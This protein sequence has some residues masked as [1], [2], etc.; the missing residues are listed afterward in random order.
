M[1]KLLEL[2]TIQNNLRSSALS[3]SNN[4]DNMNTT[5]KKESKL[6][7]KH[8][9]IYGLGN[10][11][12]R[13]V[14]FLMI[15]IYTR[16]LSPTDYG[17]LEIVTLTT[18]II[19]LVASAGVTQGIV[20]FYF[21][22][23]SEKDK[24]EVMS[25]SIIAFSIVSLI[26]LIPVLCFSS[27]LAELLLDSSDQRNLFMVSIGTI[28]FA[29]LSQIGFYYLRILKQSSRFMIYSVAKLVLA[30]SLNIY[31]IVVLDTGVIGVLYST[32]ISAAG[33]T[34]FLTFPIFKQTGLRFS[35]KKFKEL[36]KFGLPIIP[37]SI[38]NLVI[39]VS[40]KFFLRF[41][42]SLADTGLYSLAAR[43]AVIPGYFIVYP[44]MQIWEVRRLEIYKQ[45]NSE[46]I[47]GQVFTY[48]CLLISFVGLGISVL[49]RD[50]IEIMADPKFWDA[51]KAIPV[52]VLAQIILSFF[53]HFNLGILITKKTKLFT[54]IDVTNGFFNLIFNYILIKQFGMMGAAYATLTSYSLRV[55]MV[56]MVSIR[57]YRIYFEVSR[58]MKIFFTAGVIYWAG[59][60]IHGQNLYMNLAFKTSLLILFP[61]ILVMI[62]FFRPDELDWIKNTVRNHRLNP[63]LKRNN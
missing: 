63:I 50:A 29:S 53:Q 18:Q 32:L 19:A 60:M 58:V 16:F 51:Y 21:E 62:R 36:L 33:I 4:R 25:T 15:P 24:N 3:A 31:F 2:T 52:L 20:R 40:D 46:Q 55:I 10:V 61:V 41:M 11:F 5:V 48:F 30:L 49:S 27:S 45:P 17:I 8:T 47:M 56:Y 38:G 28:W 43:F 37:A 1:V 34:L 59:L 44:F 42:V 57:F 7:S 12:N 9:L 39:L 14:G 54:Y 26:V 6:L 13:V 22:Y 23:E 35:K